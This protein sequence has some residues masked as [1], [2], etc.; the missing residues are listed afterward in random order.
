MEPVHFAAG[1]QSTSAEIKNQ[2]QDR[3]R[4]AAWRLLKL[5]RLAKTLNGHIYFMNGNSYLA[6]CRISRTRLCG[7]TKLVTE[8]ILAACGLCTA[9]VMSSTAASRNKTAYAATRL[10]DFHDELKHSLLLKDNIP[11]LVAAVP[12][13]LSL[14]GQLRLLGFSAAAKSVK[15]AV[16][17]KW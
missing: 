1:H 14:T 6:Y 9:L 10:A 3:T 13:A 11:D 5:Y 4:L 12:M 7:L 2:A 17:K 16:D 15:L 8:D